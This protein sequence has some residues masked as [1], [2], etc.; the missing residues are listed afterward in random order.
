MGSLAGWVASAREQQAAEFD[1][2]I[3]GACNGAVGILFGYAGSEFRRGGLGASTSA[4]PGVVT[5]GSGAAVSAASGRILSGVSVKAVTGTVTVLSGDAEPHD[6]AVGGIAP[7]AARSCIGCSCQ[8]QPSG[9]SS[10][11]SKN[12]VRRIRVS[13]C[14]WVHGRCHVHVHGTSAR[15]W[16]V[17]RYADASRHGPRPACQMDR[18]PYRCFRCTTGSSAQ[19]PSN[20][21]HGWADGQMDGWMEAGPVPARPSWKRMGPRLECCYMYSDIR[22][23]AMGSRGETEDEAGGQEV[24]CTFVVSDEYRIQVDR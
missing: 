14:R 11:R 10:P 13:S 18:K 4:V 9:P 17:V 23:E 15:A 12:W 8:M 5:V 16:V 3:H 6:R 19:R 20:R 24:V 1:Y 21:M 2:P 22:I 7:S